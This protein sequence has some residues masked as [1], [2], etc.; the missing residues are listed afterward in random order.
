[1]EIQIQKL[2]KHGVEISVYDPDINLST[3]IGSNLNYLKMQIPNIAEIICD[4]INQLTK[5]VSVIVITQDRSE[6]T[7][8]NSA[9]IK[10][11]IVIDLV[12]NKN[13]TDSATL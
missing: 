5:R 6:F 7:L 12:K 8:I 10:E 1:M 4:D 9:L 11:K 13:W 3:M 2:K